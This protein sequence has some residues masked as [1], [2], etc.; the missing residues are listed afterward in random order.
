MEDC[1]REQ[2]GRILARNT[3]E[4]PW[5]HR[6]DLRA[7]QTVEARGFSAQVTLDML[8]VLNLL[9][10]S[11]GIVQVANPVVQLFRVRRDDEELG[12]DP[13]VAIYMGAMQRDRESG[14]VRAVRPFAPEVP[15]S[16]WRAQLGVRVSLGN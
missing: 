7:S 2:R 12:L 3:C 13:M 11:W 14:K 15:S 1:L 16:Q 5:S 6:L 9:N 4:T 8:N 10:S